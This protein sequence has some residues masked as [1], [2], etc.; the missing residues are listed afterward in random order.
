MW[1]SWVMGLGHRAGRDKRR[2]SAGSRLERRVSA[3]AERSV[4]NLWHKVQTEQVHK[5][6]ETDLIQSFQGMPRCNLKPYICPEC[7]TSSEKFACFAYSRAVCEGSKDSSSEAD[8]LIHLV[9]SRQGSTREG[10]QREQSV[11]ITMPSNTTSLLAWIG[12]IHPSQSSDS[13]RWPDYLRLLSF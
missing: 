5:G 2:R 10:E 1:A 12:E 8:I 9:R 7:L 11:S 3:G 4:I 6:A 13:H